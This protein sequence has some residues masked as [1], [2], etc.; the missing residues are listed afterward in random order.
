VTGGYVYRGTDQPALQGNKLPTTM[1]AGVVVAQA[2]AEHGLAI[3]RT[4]SC[5]ESLA[6]LIEAKEYPAGDTADPANPLWR[7]G[8]RARDKRKSL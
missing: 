4:G 1:W 6:T 3:L 7:S 8:T 2:I 5:K